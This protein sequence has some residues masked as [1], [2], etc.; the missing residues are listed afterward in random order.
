MDD[1]YC[2]IE[3]RGDVF[4]FGQVI[5]ISFQLD[6]VSFELSFEAN[7]SNESSRYFVAEI[8]EELVGYVIRFERHTFHANV[9]RELNHWSL[10]RELRLGL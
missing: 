4:L 3:R 10:S 1:L 7:S 9:R 2:G 6:C 5:V 8:N